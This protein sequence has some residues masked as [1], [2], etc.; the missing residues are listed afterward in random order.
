MVMSNRVQRGDQGGIVDWSS[1]GGGGF[2][3]GA[4]TFFVTNFFQIKINYSLIFP[5]SLLIGFINHKTGTQGLTN[6]K[7]SGTR[8]RQGRQGVELVFPSVL[9]NP[10]EKLIIGK[11]HQLE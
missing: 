6:R 8:G 3:A 11:T 7:K 5:I 9:G 4:R 2:F 10:L 1:L